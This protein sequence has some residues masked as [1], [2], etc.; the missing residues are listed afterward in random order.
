MDVLE[1]SNTAVTL[2]TD[3][4]VSSLFIISSGLARFS[5]LVIYSSAARDHCQII[6]T[7]D[8]I[9]LSNM[10]IERV[11]TSTIGECSVAPI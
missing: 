7:A 5:D 10:L 2:S 4:T 11:D 6:T 1:I 8:S 9:S 3:A